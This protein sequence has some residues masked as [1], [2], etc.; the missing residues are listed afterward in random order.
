M[1]AIVAQ[2]CAK[3]GAARRWDG[4]LPD[5]VFPERQLEKAKRANRPTARDRATALCGSSGPD[6]KDST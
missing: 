3:H 4:L 6:G 5:C 2:L 1:I